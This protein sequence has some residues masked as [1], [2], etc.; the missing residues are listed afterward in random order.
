ME[1][2]LSVCNALA[3]DIIINFLVQLIPETDLRSKLDNSIYTKPSFSVPTRMIT[4]SFIRWQNDLFNTFGKTIIEQELHFSLP[5][6]VRPVVAA[7]LFHHMFPP[8]RQVL[9]PTMIPSQSTMQSK[10]LR[11]DHR[12]WKLILQKSYDRDLLETKGTHPSI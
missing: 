4:S 6:G 1:D 10:Y 3:L 12:S 9:H 2:D 8:S 5:G 7:F 11:K